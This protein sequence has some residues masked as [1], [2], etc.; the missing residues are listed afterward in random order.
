VR[1]AALATSTFPLVELA[2]VFTLSEGVLL[3]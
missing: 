3:A 2:R 1:Y